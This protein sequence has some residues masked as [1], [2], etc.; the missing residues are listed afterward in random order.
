M[1]TAIKL[2]NVTKTYNNN[3]IL[4]DVSVDIPF[5]K[6]GVVGKNGAGKTT[7]LKLLAK[8]EKPDSGSI[9]FCEL[10]NKVSLSSDCIVYP[11]FLTVSNIGYLYARESA[12]NDS[13]FR[14]YINL[15]GLEPHIDEAVCNLSTGSLQKLRLSIALSSKHQFLML[16]EPLNGLDDCSAKLALD[17]ILA[18]SRPMLI[19][20]HENRFTHFLKGTLHIEHGTCNLKI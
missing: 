6:V 14:R 20:D 19:V 16:D 1:K 12:I 3:L 11:E 9:S 8:F 10:V 17:E 2:K 15:F 18:D 7:F 13:I 5:E 4:N